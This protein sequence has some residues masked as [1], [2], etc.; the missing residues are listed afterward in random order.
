MF[1]KRL[2]DFINWWITGLTYLLPVSFCNVIA[3]PTDR[4]TIS[5]DG[6]RIIFRHYRGHSL[7]I[8]SERSCLTEN[9]DIEK[10]LTQ[11]WLTKKSKA[12][13]EIIL[14]VA[15]EKVLRKTILL[16]L[17]ALEN[18]REILGFEMDRQTPFLVEQVYFDYLLEENGEGN[19]QLKVQLF[20]SPKEHI[21]QMLRLLDSWHIKPNVIN[22]IDPEINI[23]SLNLLP[24][25]KRNTDSNRANK[26]TLLL[27]ITAFCLFLAVLYVPLIKQDDLL[28]QLEIEISNSRDVVTK[29]KDLKLQ[30]DA[31]FDKAS[32]LD[33]K[34]NDYIPVIDVL[35]ELTRIIPDD[36]WLIRFSLSNGEIQLQGESS[37]ASSMIQSIESSDILTDVKFR[38]PVIN[39]EATRKDKF[40]ISAKLF[41]YKP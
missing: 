36:T 39:N 12:E 41:G 29:L 7:N 15:D 31:L 16:P 5:F 28:N 40:N 34:H 37:I 14:L 26:L 32:F 18:L 22:V 19:N 11:E 8:I 30:K 23:S 17:A 24:A 6:D 3:P 4:I 2:Q 33:S 9:D 1:R 38:S 20:A 27:V 35:N 21:D 10:A 25:E 13:P